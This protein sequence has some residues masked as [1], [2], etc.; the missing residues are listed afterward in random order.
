[1]VCENEK[2][3]R[4]DSKKMLVCTAVKK[5]SGDVEIVKRDGKKEDTMSVGSFLSQVYGRPV[6][7]MLN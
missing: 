6:T 5:E 2:Q 1:M 4:T 7:I 3:I